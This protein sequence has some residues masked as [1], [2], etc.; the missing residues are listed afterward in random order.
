MAGATKKCGKR[1]W[2]CAL[3]ALAAKGLLAKDPLAREE[4]GDE[5]TTFDR[6]ETREGREFKVYRVKAS[7]ATTGTAAKERCE[8]SAGRRAARGMFR[9]MTGATSSTESEAAYAMG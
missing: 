9:E 1:C 2:A 7:R 8:K 5:M 4:G 6:T 3:D